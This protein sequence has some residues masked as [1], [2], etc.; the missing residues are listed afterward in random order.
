MAAPGAALPSL[1]GGGGS[2]SMSWPTQNPAASVSH[3]GTDVMSTPAP[4]S[5]RPTRDELGPC[6]IP[7]SAVGH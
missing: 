4:G 6:W 5:P 3:G 1:R 2:Q 7:G